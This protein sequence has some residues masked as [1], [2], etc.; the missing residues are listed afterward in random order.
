MRRVAKS[1]I[2]ALGGLSLKSSGSDGCGYFLVE[3]LGHTMVK[4]LPALCP[5]CCKE[6]FYADIA[7]VRVNG[8]VF[9]YADDELIAAESGQIQFTSYGISGIVTFQLSVYAAINIKK[10]KSVYAV[11][12]FALPFSE[13]DLYNTFACFAKNNPKRSCLGS[14]CGILNQKLSA[15][16]LKLSD[17]PFDKRFGEL[18]ESEIRRIIYFIKHFRT[19]IKEPLGLEKAQVTAGGA[20]VSEINPLTMESRIHK[21]IYFA[22]EMIDV[23]GKCGGYNL[24]WAWSSAYVAAKSAIGEYNAQSK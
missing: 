10:G 13:D 14:L 22:G 4:P 23:D 9:L 3:K 6:D 20:D 16:I 12:D 18:K 24:Q 11:L 19:E 21:G 8:K 5:L 7:G 15:A 2:F 17:I 1:V